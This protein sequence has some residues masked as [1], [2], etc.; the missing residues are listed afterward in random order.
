M[1]SSDQY[2][3]TMSGNVEGSSRS[4]LSEEDTNNHTPKEHGGLVEQRLV[5]GWARHGGR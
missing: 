2:N 1:G 4:N 3:R 5:E